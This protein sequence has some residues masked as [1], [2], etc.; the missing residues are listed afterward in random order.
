MKAK[1]FFGKSLYGRCYIGLAL[2]KMLITVSPTRGGKGSC[3]IIP[4]ALLWPGSL[5][6]IDLKDGENAFR[7]AQ[8]RRDVLGQNVF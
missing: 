1:A 2:K 8:Y 6:V 7:T 5:I 3:C 4:N